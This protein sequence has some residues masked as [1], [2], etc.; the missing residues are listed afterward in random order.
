MKT[1]LRILLLL[2]P[3]FVRSQITTPVIKANFGLDGDVK[4]N[5]INGFLQSGNDDWYPNPALASVCSPGCNGQFVI[6]TTGAA[7]IVAGYISNPATRLNSFWRGMSRPTYSIVN[8]RVLWLDAIYIRDYHAPDTTVFVQ[9]SKNGESPAIWTGG[10]QAIPQK[11]DIL[12]AFMHIRRAGPNTTDSLW[13]FGG[14]SVDFPDADRFYD[15]E[16]FQTDLYYDRVSQ[17]FYGYGPDLGHT[18]WQFDASGAVTKPGDACFAYS[19]KGASSPPTYTIETRIW[20]SY[21]TWTTVTPTNFS[22]GGAF[23]GDG[24]GAAYGYASIVPK[25]AGSYFLGLLNGNNEYGGPF[26]VVNG[27]NSLSPTFATKQFM[28]FG[29]NLTKLGLDPVTTAGT[30]VCGSPFNRLVVKTRASESF[31]ASLKDF[32]APTDLF[33]APRALAAASIPIFCGTIGVSTIQVQN[34]SGSSVYS[35]TTPDGHIVGSTSGTSI[36]VDAPGNYIVTQRLALVCNP[37]A[38]D[39]VTVAYDPNCVPLDNNVLSFKAAINN[40]MTKLDWSVAQNRDI[41]YFEIERSFDG[42]DF[43]FVSHI[44]ADSGKDQFASYTAYDDLSHMPVQ[45]AVFYRLK[46]KK[47]NGSMSYSKIVRIPYGS[48]ITKISIAPN[49]VHDMM[50][51]TINKNNKDLMELNMYDISGKAVRYIKTDLEAGINVISVDNL[52]ELQRGMYL[53]IVSTGGETFRQ[54]IVLA[55]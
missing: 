46:L 16:M 27:D 51:I 19:Y 6:D 28:E 43:D 45:P 34:P 1:F 29:V 50:Q 55:Q 11:N 26:Q 23:D 48:L 14:L 38:Y 4:A 12:D 15:F 42:R 32:V 33:L 30:D 49:P 44:D 40:S 10:V 39:T 35:W 36:T 5:Y 31:T 9:A 7:A 25:T 22:W 3:I 17:R 53:V 8:N 41:S 47:A 52:S 21:T 18:S 2:S 54:K 37:Y 20:V 24:A 13:M